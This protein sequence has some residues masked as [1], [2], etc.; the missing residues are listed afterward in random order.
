MGHCNRD[1]PPGIQPH[2]LSIPE[3]LAGKLLARCN[4][5]IGGQVEGRKCWRVQAIAP[6]KHLLVVAIARQHTQRHRR[7]LG[8]A[9]KITSPFQP[10]GRLL[11]DRRVV[12]TPD[13]P[14][15]PPSP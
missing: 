3:H 10:G 5:V 6:M 7:L 13:L 14:W 4:D 12:L 9:N 15:T 1:L 8:G 2:A 11:Y